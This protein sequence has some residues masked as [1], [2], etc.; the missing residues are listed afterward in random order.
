MRRL[1]YIAFILSIW[2]AAQAAAGDL[3]TSFGGSGTGRFG[4]GLG[5]DHGRAA[6]V[7]ADGKLVVGGFSGLPTGNGVARV[8]YTTNNVLDPSFGQGGRVLTKFGVSA[9]AVTSLPSLVCLGI[10]S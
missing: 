6:A 9:L 2:F 10:R 3:D 8:R 7:Q 1:C 4:F 5:D